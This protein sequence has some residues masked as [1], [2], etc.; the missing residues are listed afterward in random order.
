MTVAARRIFY[1][2]ATAAFLVAAPVLVLIAQGYRVDIK[3]FRLVRTGA[4]ALSST[5]RSQILIDGRDRGMSPVL[6]T[7]LSQGRYQV[8]FRR[9]GFQGWKT[10]VEVAPSRSVRVDASL[11]PDQPE[12]TIL[13][14]VQPIDWQVVSRQNEI[15]FL[16]RKTDQIVELSTFSASAGTLSS[17]IE[18]TNIDDQAKLWPS[19]DGSAVFVQT[20]QLFLLVQP[21]LAPDLDPVIGRFKASAVAWSSTS[22]I[23]F[24]LDSGEVSSVDPVSA[25]R[26]SII[27][28]GVSQIAVS[29]AG[30]WTLRESNEATRLEFR[31][32][33]DLQQIRK[34]FA[35]L[36]QIT[37][38]V[39]TK[40]DYLIVEKPSSSLILDRDGVMVEIPVSQVS[41]LF[42]GNRPGLAILTSANDVWSIDLINRTAALIDRRSDLVDA[43][44]IPNTDNL[45]ILTGNDSRVL[46]LSDQNA[47]PGKVEVPL[48]AN[49]L[50][51]TV[52]G[53]A[54]SDGSSLRQI[55]F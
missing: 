29:N 20:G 34:V 37:V 22:E 4:L 42:L 15:I 5:P 9:A 41:K 17:R 6:I 49:R 8:E 28:G 11:L 36:G 53:L 3:H 24:L 39:G 50:E 54:L 12:T 1:L 14:Q 33:S 31:T 48:T 55:R 44:W 51:V 25:Q 30:L 52:R 10:S 19:P 21:E 2:S 35:D 27:A 47:D 45:V 38:L 46:V 40:N 32:I 13:S 26:Q 43:A 18:L 23:A 16:T 7:G